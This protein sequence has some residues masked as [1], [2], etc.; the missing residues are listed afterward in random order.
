MHHSVGPRTG[1]DSTAG[2]N[3]TIEMWARGTYVHREFASRRESVQWRGRE[4]HPRGGDPEQDVDE[5]T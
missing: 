2:S 4:S 1:H 3:Q 5:R